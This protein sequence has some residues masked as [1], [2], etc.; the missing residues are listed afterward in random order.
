[1]G[2]SLVPSTHTNRLASRRERE[3]HEKWP[4][5]ARHELPR[6]KDTQMTTAT[7]LR[8]AAALSAAGVL[9]LLAGLLLANVGAYSGFPDQP[10]ELV[11]FNEDHEGTLESAWLVVRPLGVL[12]LLGLAAVLGAVTT[13][14]AARF[15]L[16]CGGVFAALALTA[17]VA[18]ST[19]ASVLGFWEAASDPDGTMSFL[20]LSLAFH[21]D[22]LAF[23]VLAAGMAVA[24]VALTAAGFLGSRM[25]AALVVLALL[26][27]VGG[28]LGVPLFVLWGLTLAVAL[29]RASRTA[30]AEGL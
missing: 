30:D 2:R 28:S 19:P 11:R 14:A 27:A 5:E 24:A 3:D 12:L 25:R 21:L 29:F 26:M 8:T 20:S 13:G 10:D 7:S 22:F 23:A 16:L 18:A 1:M 15:V 9:L 17:G 4:W 6:P